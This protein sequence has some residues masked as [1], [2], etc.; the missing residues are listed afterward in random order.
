MR[1]FQ[2]STDRRQTRRSGAFYRASQHF[3]SG[4]DE[5]SLDWMVSDTKDFT[6]FFQPVAGD[7]DAVVDR[8]I[9]TEILAAGVARGERADEV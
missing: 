9:Y 8:R 1:V 5:T 4:F 2:D 6:N 3:S 7:G